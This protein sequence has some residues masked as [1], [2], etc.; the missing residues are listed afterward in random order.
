MPL[1]PPQK[2]MA[3]PRSS[4]GKT[5]EMMDRVLGIIMAPPSPWSARNPMSHPMPGASPQASD[6]R[7]KSTSARR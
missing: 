6:A 5:L 1:T 7:V 4:G 2:P 3:L